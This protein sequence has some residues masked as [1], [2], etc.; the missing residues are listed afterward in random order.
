ML[1]PADSPVTGA[2][3]VQV[4]DAH[5]RPEVGAWLDRLEGPA[6]VVEWGWP[7]SADATLPRICPRGSSAPG[8]AAVTELLRQAGWDR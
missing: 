2:A 7:G 8:I 1:T 6:V 5:R 3:V 4:R